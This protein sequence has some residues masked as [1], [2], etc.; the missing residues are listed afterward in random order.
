MTEENKNNAPVEE[1][2]AAAEVKPEAAAGKGT[3]FKAK[4]SAMKRWQVTLVAI[5]AVIVVAGGGFMVWHDQPSFC[6]AICH[7]PMDN[8]VDGYFNDENQLAYQHAHVGG[9]SLAAGTL[10]E[11]VAD[12]N[13][14]CLTCHEAHLDE[15]MK[16]GISWVSGNY[17]VD[18]DGN[19][20]IAEPAYVGNK[21][22]CTECHDY[23]KVIAA[24]EHYWGEDEPA[25]PHASHQG[26][27][28]CNV[29]H[30]PHGTSVL[31]CDSCHNFAVPE[32]WE[33]PSQAQ[34]SAQ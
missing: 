6:N 23:D 30:Q 28:D 8:Y 10:K 34:A 16:E 4:V 9:T 33:T 5:I 3:G 18:T 12:K 14:K 15:Q 17:K 1:Q 22:F 2:E 11:G 26:E 27:L 24:T 21:E 7:T 29:C 31:M 20:V 25:N 32:G 19:P 13:L